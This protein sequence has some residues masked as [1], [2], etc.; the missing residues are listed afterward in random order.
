MPYMRLYEIGKTF[1]TMENLEDVGKPPDSKYFVAANVEDAMDGGVIPVGM[2]YAV[3]AFSLMNI[4]LNMFL[5]DKIDGKLSGPVW[6][7]TLVSPTHQV[8]EQF[9]VFRGIMVWPN[10]EA[11]SRRFTGKLSDF[12]VI[13]RALIEQNSTYNIS[14]LTATA[15]SGNM[16]VQFTSDIVASRWIVKI[17]FVSGAIMHRTVLHTTAVQTHNIAI[18]VGVSGAGATVRVSSNYDLL[19]YAEVTAGGGP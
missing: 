11:D 13:I 2:P 19:E 12:E 7:T 5:K 6:I 1:E 18:P 14:S 4:P 3:W 17:T 10:T 15:S 8:T 16:A 9:R